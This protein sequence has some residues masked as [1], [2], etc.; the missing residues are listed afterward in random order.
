MTFVSGKATFRNNLTRIKIFLPSLVYSATKLEVSC[1]KCWL[2][3]SS[4]GVESVF[5]RCCCNEPASLSV[6][7]LVDFQSNVVIKRIRVGVG[8]VFCL[9]YN[10]LE[11]KHYFTKDF[12]G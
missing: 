12:N 2:R 5:S 6:N 7:H 11:I 4:K 10:S 1:I 8:L 9:V 3:F